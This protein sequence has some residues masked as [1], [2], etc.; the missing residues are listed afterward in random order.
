MPKRRHRGMERR[1][2]LERMT[3]LF[4]LAESEAMQEHPERARRYVELARKIGMRYNV[5]TPANFRRSFCKS[6]RAYL[7]P[8]RNARVRVDEG[9]IIVTCGAC[10]AVQRRPYRREQAARRKA[11]ARS[12]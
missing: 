1:I 6:C 11:R 5:R 12:Q 8:S 2:A 4:R 10:G 3:T 7:V 9:R